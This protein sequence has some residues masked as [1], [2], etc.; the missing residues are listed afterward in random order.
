MKLRRIA[1]FTALLALFACIL[2]ACAP[3]QVIEIDEGKLT[4]YCF[5]AGKA[6]AFL[7]YT[8][9]SAVLIDA[10]ESGC[11]KA[12]VKYCSER[13]ITKIDCM[14]VT[15]F[16]KDHVGGARKVLETL[17]V[18]RVLQSSV[19]KDSGAYDKYLE[20]LKSTNMTAET[21]REKTTF[22]LDGVSYT[23][24]PPESD[25]YDEDDTNN[26]SLITEIVHGN[27]SMLFTG[28]ARTARIAEYLKTEPGTF[29][30]LKMPHHGEYMKE[31]K[32]L[33]ARVRP[34]YAVITS[35]LQE[36]E[37]D[38]TVSLLK[39]YSTE[40]FNTKQAPVIITSDG[41]TIEVGYDT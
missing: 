40:I 8:K 30:L 6:D 14:I 33:M 11:G 7:F 2:A 20:A 28:D 1:L 26:A 35:S 41:S 10:G 17:N 27:V 34:A 38:K 3:P 15:H 31:L 16:D 37:E 32:K 9:N 12:I 25:V 18:A 13:G 21:V 36:P 23:V 24:L 5:K 4:V 39:N 29:D 19:P 22:T